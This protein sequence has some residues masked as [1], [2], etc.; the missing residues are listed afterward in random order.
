M[1]KAL[2]SRNKR[3]ATCDC[4]GRVLAPNEGRLVY[5]PI[6]KY[7]YQCERCF[8]AMESY[9]HE[10]DTFKTEKGK[11][12]SITT[13]FELEL[14]KGMSPR[15]YQGARILGAYGFTPSYDCTCEIEW[16]SPVYRNLNG[17][18]KLLYSVMEGNEIELNNNVGTH[19]NVWSEE[20]T[21]R[22]FDRIRNYYEIIFKP[23]YLEV[24]NNDSEQKHRA[25]FGRGIWDEDDEGRRWALGFGNDY[26]AAFVN[27]E[28]CKRDH[29][30]I[31][32]RLCKYSNNKQF[33]NCLRFANDFMKTILVN[34]SRNYMTDSEARA[35]GKDASFASAHNMHKAKIT[36]QKLVKVY[37]KYME[38][39]QNL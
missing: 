9:S 18:A 17:I 24:R 20:L 36:A 29:P 26:H 25:L 19:V 8:N 12:I 37:N 5:S 11:T 38:K 34:F 30:R 21:S 15:K 31:E 32:L 22:D 14:N 23:L 1:G 4:C 35:M 10:V 39:A 2:G 6:T 13:G 3:Q 7:G 28:S 33:M 16:K 27:T